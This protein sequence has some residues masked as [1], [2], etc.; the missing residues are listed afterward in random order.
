MD[1]NTRYCVFW[2]PTIFHCEKKNRIEGN[3]VGPY[4]ID[5]KSHDKKLLLEITREEQKTDNQSLKDRYDLIFK[6]SD[7]DGCSFDTRFNCVDQSRNGFV[8]YSYDREKL[9]SDYYSIIVKDSNDSDSE[10]N[11]NIDTL[12]I[13]FYH[14]AKLFYHEH[15]SDNECDGKYASY[16]Y[17][18]ETPHGPKKYLSEK[19][20]LLKKNNSVINWYIDQF[21]KQ[22]VSN[23]EDISQKLRD[24]TPQIKK[25]FEAKTIVNKA[26]LG[27][28][29]DK[30][31]NATKVL[32]ALVG[33][34][35]SGIP[36]NLISIQ[37]KKSF[38]NNL[39]RSNISVLTQNCFE[40]LT[41]FL[42]LCNNS[43]IE[44]TYCKTLLESKY[45]DKYKHDS[46]ITEAE[47]EQRSP[48]IEI[49]DRCRKKAFN[50]RNSIRY[51]EDAKRKCEIWQNKITETL[52]DE[53]NELSQNH[54]DI[55]KSLK[56]ITSKVDEQVLG[57]GELT[58][59]VKEQITENKD[60][61]LKVDTQVTEVQ[62]LLNKS[63][64]TNK[65]SKRLG[66]LSVGLAFVSIGIAFFFGIK[67]STIQCNCTLCG[68]HS[69]TIDS[70]D[71]TKNNLSN[72]TSV[73]V[74]ISSDTLTDDKSALPVQTINHTKAI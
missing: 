54:E 73:L 20:L 46:E 56:E 22:I 57:V 48:E 5:D 66:W 29:E 8:I 41:V 34:R 42:L 55:L 53:I 51:I 37:E 69:L 65:I 72:V 10:K 16:F 31:E 71:S 43:L 36:E 24:W 14:Y 30:I 68:S 59:E 27:D 58:K 6:L 28:N 60:L 44:Y 63:E 50:I 12:F 11:D 2:F 15:E 62:E 19:P 67:G 7:K 25:Y 1:T 26:L 45:N 9:I 39:Y 38:L 74:E 17:T 3:S 35:P 61:T 64:K 40:N 33:E 49:K 47:L 21:E 52:L 4:D 18:Q 13:S 70:V 23:A 32:Q